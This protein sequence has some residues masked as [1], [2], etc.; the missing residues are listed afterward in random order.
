MCFDWRRVTKGTKECCNRK[1][2]T[3]AVAEHTAT[4]C[5][6]RSRG[7]IKFR[8]PDMIPSNQSCIAPYVEAAQTTN[9]THTPRRTTDVSGLLLQCKGSTESGVMRYAPSL[10]QDFGI[11]TL[12]SY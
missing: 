11:N 5:I 4:G 9:H 12:G 3:L 2:A 7:N 6:D 10:P 1:V 8:V